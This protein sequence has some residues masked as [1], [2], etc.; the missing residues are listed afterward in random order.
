MEKKYKVSSIIKEII[1]YSIS[2]FIALVGVVFLIL[3]IVGANISQK[4]TLAK[5]QENFSWRWIGLI[6]IGVAVIFA[7]IVLLVSARKVD[8]VIEREQRRKQRLTAMMSDANKE[9]NTVYVENGKLVN[10]TH[11]IIDKEDDPSLKPTGAKEM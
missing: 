8:R 10:P 11:T 1:C 3:G 2:G 9:E 4:S 6:L 7:L 5:I